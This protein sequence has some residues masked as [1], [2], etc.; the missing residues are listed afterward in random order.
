[1]GNIRSLGGTSTYCSV[2][3]LPDDVAVDVVVV[4]VIDVVVVVVIIDAVVVAVVDVD[5]VVVA[6]VDVDVVAVVD[7]VTVLVLSMA[8]YAKLREN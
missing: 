7:P 3:E 5:A 8:I 1:M 4:V 2:A 6:V